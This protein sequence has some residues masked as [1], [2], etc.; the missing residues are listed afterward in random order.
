MNEDIMKEKFMEI[1]WEEA[2]QAFR[3]DEVPVGACVVSGR[4][5]SS[6]S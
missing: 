6:L 5:C 3:E 4:G 2:Q 1:A